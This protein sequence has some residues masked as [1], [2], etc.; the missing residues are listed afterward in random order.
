MGRNHPPVQGSGHG[1]LTS[2]PETPAPLVG[3]GGTPL[4]PARGMNLAALVLAG[5]SSALMGSPHCVAMC[6]G[7]AAAAH[8]K[9]G[10]AWHFGRVS[11]Y[12]G[13]GALAGAAGAPLVAGA[14]WVRWLV[15]GMLIWACASLAGLVSPLAPRIPGVKAALIWAA[16]RP[17]AGGTILFGAFTALLPCGLSWSVL[18]LASVGGSA[19]HGALLMLGFGLG[20]LPALWI[21][22][23]GIHRLSSLNPWV[24]R[25]LA[26]LLLG[27]GLWSVMVRAE[28]A[29]TGPLCHGPVGLEE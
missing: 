8:E 6:G 5:L 28:P 27:S 20:T 13:L 15:A 25:G 23:R 1:R 19:V 3:P 16:R 10:L 29:P 4:A 21:A 14:D 9:S 7:F 18:V 11:V 12:L 2:A 24:R 22:A 17:G 26:G